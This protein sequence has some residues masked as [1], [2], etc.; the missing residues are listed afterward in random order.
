MRVCTACSLM[1]MCLAS[2]SWFSI[3]RLVVP[4]CF[5]FERMDGVSYCAFGQMKLT[6]CQKHTTPPHNLCSHKLP[7]QLLH[8]G[9]IPGSS[10]TSFLPLPSLPLTPC[11]AWS[12]DG[13]L[14]HDSYFFFKKAMTFPLTQQEDA[15]RVSKSWKIQECFFRIFPMG[16]QNVRK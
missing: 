4:H 10:G 7:E 1:I 11:R 2:C 5:A 12:M 14:T 16:V 9:T 3:S 8:S 15:G 6:L 13:K